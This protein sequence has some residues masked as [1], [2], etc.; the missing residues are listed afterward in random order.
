MVHEAAV[1]GLTLSWGFL[2]G[3]TDLV[4]RDAR[5]PLWFESWSENLGGMEGRIRKVAGCAWTAAISPLRVMNRMISGPYFFVAASDHEGV[6]VKLSLHPVYLDGSQIIPVD[7]HTERKRASQLIAA[8][9]VP[10]HPLR[11]DDFRRVCSSLGAHL[12]C[13]IDVPA[14]RADYLYVEARRAI[15][16]E[17]RGFMPGRL[18]EYDAHFDHK[19]LQTGDTGLQR[20]FLDGCKLP[21]APTVG[22][23]YR[24]GGLLVQTDLS[25]L[26][27]LDLDRIS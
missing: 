9:I 21:E 8:G 2:R 17:I 1:W 25:S 11:M 19:R 7:S 15:F 22:S 13:P 20:R 26:R 14:Y 23:V 24:D 12:G 16:E 27:L 3:T 10:Y 4:P 18:P 5:I 6:V